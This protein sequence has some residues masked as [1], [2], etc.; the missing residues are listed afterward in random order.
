MACFIIDDWSS[1]SSATAPPLLAAVW[2]SRRTRFAPAALPAEWPSG[3]A[4]SV[5]LRFFVAGL[6]AA[7][8]IE[9]A[10]FFQSCN[11]T[12]VMEAVNNSCVV[13][14][15]TVCVGGCTSFVMEAAAVCECDRGGGRR[16]GGGVPAHP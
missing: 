3:S 15:A 5:E 4:P 13:E 1:S 9:S 8:C 11:R 6:R 12:Y 2:L 14:A 7:G 10:F 16:Q